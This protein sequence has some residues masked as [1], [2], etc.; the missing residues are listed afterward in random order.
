MMMINVKKTK[1]IKDGYRRHSCTCKSTKINC[2]IIFVMYSGIT[3]VGV[4]RGSNWGCHPYFFLKKNWWPFLLVTVTF[5]AFTRV[6]PPGGCHPVPFLPVQPRLSSI[7]CKFAHIFLFG[8][9]PHGGCHPGWSAPS[10][11]VMS[12]VM[13][14]RAQ[15][16]TALLQP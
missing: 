11:P 9:H 12:L 13:Y 5:I 3:R 4:T 16:S 1:F 7:L 10:P 8:C 2:F 14:S 6:P 15:H